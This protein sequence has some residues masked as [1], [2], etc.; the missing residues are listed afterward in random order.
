M[1]NVIS[2]GAFRAIDPDGWYSVTQAADLCGVT[3][4]TVLRWIGFRKLEAVRLAGNDW[5]VSGAAIIATAPGIYAAPSAKVETP[6][7][8]AK[9]A[10]EAMK[11]INGGA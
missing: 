7:G 5:R 11:R 2:G 9:R 6:T 3:R 10:D 4:I 1:T 8:R